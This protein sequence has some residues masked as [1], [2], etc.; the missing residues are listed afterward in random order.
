MTDPN[1]LLSEVSSKFGAPHGRSNVLDNPMS[2]VT[3]FRMRMV[4]G[5]Y[6]TGGAYWGGGKDVDP[7]YAA[8]GAEF[9]YFVRA[10]SLADAKDQIQTMYPNLK[11]EFS[12]VNDDFVSGYI[13]AALWSSVDDDDIPLDSK[14][15]DD[16]ISDELMK[17]IHSDCQDFLHQCQHLLTEEKCERTDGNFMETA[18]YC[19]WLS[20]GGHGVSFLDHWERT[21]AKI[22]DSTARKFA[23]VSLFVED[24]KIYS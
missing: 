19:F 4:D 15:S 2:T 21:S 16:D 5:D 14:Y 6:D 13:K 17:K 10:K 12:E 9:E 7:M 24:G 20:R 18:G 11:I 3:L 1:S 8:I 22:L 23:E